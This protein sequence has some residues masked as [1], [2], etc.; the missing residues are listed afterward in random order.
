MDQLRNAL[1]AATGAKMPAPPPSDGLP[2]PLRS[3]WVARLRE[4]GADVPREPTMGQ[5][6]QRS[7]AMGRQLEAQGRKR[8]AAALKGL[9]QGF[10]SEREKAAWGKVKDR[11]A[12]L[13]LSEKTY[14]SLKAEEADPEKVLVKLRGDRGEALRGAGHARLRE[15]LLG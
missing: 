3:D 12:E 4:L 2:D 5:L 13:A 14:R 7:D 8:E 1:A 9:K 11:F 10:L 15:A 6:V